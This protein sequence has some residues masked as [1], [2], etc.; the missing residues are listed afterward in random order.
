[1][2]KLFRNVIASILLLCFTA[3]LFACNPEDAQ[4]RVSIVIN[5]IVTSN[6]ESLADETYGS[7][8]WIELYNASDAPV[9]LF[10]WSVTDNIKNS[11]K[12]CILPEVTIP[13]GGY[14]VLLATKQEKTDAKAWD[15]VS[16]ICLGFSL[17]STG[18]TLV[19]A[20]PYMKTV[21]EIEIPALNRDVSYARRT[22][23]T[24][25]FCT[26]PTP[27]RANDTPI[28][29]E[30]PNPVKEDFEPVTGIEISEISSR[31]TLL[32]CGGC[33]SC[34]WVELHN[35]NGADV[36]LDGFTLCDDPSDF[37]DENLS[38]TIPANGYLL[39]YC[40]KEDCAT[41]DNHLCVRLGISRYGDHLYL[42]DN[43]GNE[44]DAVE[45][46]SIP[47]K[48][49][50]Y[51]RKSDGSF[52]YCMDP[53]PA[54]ANHTEILDEPPV[55]A[56]PEPE[57]PDATEEFIDPT[58][59]ARRPSS[60]RISEVLAKNAYSIADRD[61]D[62][63]DW[64]ELRNMTDSEISLTGW[65]LSDNPKNLEKW[66]FPSDATIPANGYLLIFLSG[67]STEGGELHASF[68]LTAGETFF[69]YNDRDKTLDWI[70]IP[71]IPDNVSI[72]LDEN[73]ERV[74]F[75]HPTPMSPNG[76]AEKNAE[77]LGFFPSDG[78]YISE[79]CAI[80][81]RGSN[82]KDWIELHNGGTGTVSLDGWYLSDSIKDLKKYRISALSIE[83][84]GYAV[85]STTA[86]DFKRSGND[87][88]FGIS[89]SGETLYLSDENGEV[90]DIFDTGVQ[91]NGMTSGRIE[92]DG[93][94]RRVFFMKPTKGSAN[95][96]ERYV[97]YASEPIFSVTNLY[98]TS[99]FTLT[100]SSLD[101]NAKIYYTTDGSEP[102]MGSTYYS[103]PI[104]VS[105]NCVVRAYAVSDGLLS[106]DIV[107]YHYLFETPHTLPVVCIAMN[108]NDFKTVYNVNDHSK[109]KERKGF[110]T[111][112][113]S[114]GLIG[115]E[116]PCDIKAKG[117]G[118][119]KNNRQ[120]SLQ[121]SLRGEYGMSSV[122][123][124]FFPDYAFTEF[125]AF[126]LRQAGQDFNKARLRD[127][128]ASRAC[129]GLNVDCAN[130]RFCV[131]YVNGSY[132]GIYDFNE[133]LNSKYLQT[134]F[135]VDADSVNYV[136]RNGATVMKGTKDVFKAD[137]DM[138]RKANLSSDAAYE[139][140]I[141]KVDPDAFID[142]V[143][144][145]QFLVDTDTFNQKYWRTV[146]YGIRWR[147]I[148]YDLDL[149]YDS[150]PSRDLAYLYFNKSGTAAAHGSIT[151]FYF[152]VAL[153]TNPGWRQRFIE[154]YVELVMTQFHPDRLNALLDQMVSELEPE[155]E[156]HIKRWNNPKSV[157]E[158][159]KEVE[160]LRKKF[161]QRPEYALKHLRKE[162]SIP[163]SELDA[164]IAKYQP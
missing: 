145:R 151:Y 128:F 116:F 33:E 45:I 118:T 79:V 29:D 28:L 49:M 153:R 94:T 62:R 11:D 48:D 51:A 82:E 100:L 107:T 66:S 154:R 18:E 15:G 159:K 132:Y 38:G 105:Q 115:T 108:P 90:W 89:P 2:K 91:R 73:N 59:N 16:A 80:H 17:K 110:I 72:G 64:V 130:S 19:L 58:L 6:G 12:A 61:G 97:G 144:C 81:D 150:G 88:N 102:N 121:V 4:P 147:P 40:C 83:A 77:A 160:V 39:I 155:M 47:E 71:E 20:D 127:A 103:G 37:D 26:E 75:R 34:D 1:M 124:P 123:Y 41:K 36:V 78:V 111:Y 74:F 54:E 114:D 85:L 157:S 10:G 68:S 148:L 113:E 126:A 139:K 53:T 9:N 101:P 162:F 13:A 42:Y 119:L 69:L 50:T 31:N 125:S 23:G 112:Y 5:E 141:E 14:L 30:Q 7:P 134:H 60:V 163:Q 149:I 96:A 92:G 21:E 99:P 24:F 55:T 104:T 129:L 106:S 86:S 133:E 43:H 46:P 32:S 44:I 76:H 93:Q 27:N 98:Q 136:M 117:R 52:G 122:N 95:T 35:T 65:Y 57:T 146:D 135:G 109:I 25:G 63:S 3:G 120:K 143:I 140:F 164:L 138:A 87:G 131:M 56:T 142:Y 158:W 70:E 67:K 137:F 156:R 22:D 152:T 161:T 8:D 84:N